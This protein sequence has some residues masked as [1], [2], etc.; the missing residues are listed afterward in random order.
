MEPRA[1]LRHVRSRMKPGVLTLHGF[2]GSDRRSL[3]EML[4]E[5]DAL[6]AR[7]G[8]THD[9]IARRLRHFTDLAL[10]GFGTPIR[11]GEF[12][13]VI[14]EPRGGWLECPFGESGRY[15]KGEVRLKNL[16]I[17]QELVWTPLLVHLI[18]R[19]G[20]YEG[21]GSRYRL[22]PERVKEVLEL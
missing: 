16:R 18:G 17:G 1:K 11:E 7:L 4:R 21:R 20:F 12:E 14:H 15:R 9:V 22:D 6:V 3:E 19:H 10:Q 13:V 2:L 5:D 8:L